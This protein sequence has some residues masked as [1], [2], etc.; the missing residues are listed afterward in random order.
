MKKPPTGDPAHDVLGYERQPLDAIFRPETVALIG[1]TDKAGSVGRTVMRNLIGNPF[2]GT[3]YPVNPKRPNV[4]GIKTYPSISEVP[5]QVDLAVIVSPAP[6]VPGIIRECAEA[7]V[8][9]AIVISA[10][11]KETGEEGVE[12][13][14]QVLE[15]A[16][17]GRIR[18]IGPNCLGVMSPVSGLNATFAGSMAL[19]GNVAFLSQSGA[20][21]TAILDWSQKENVGFSHFVSV[22]SMLDVDWGDLINYLGNDRHTKSIIV[23]MESI[24]DA[25][26]FLSAAREVALTKPVIVIKAGRTEAAGKAAAS[27]TG[28]LAGSDEVLD[29]A[30]RRSGV[31]R[32]DSISDLFYMAEV[33]AKQP[34][35]KGPKLTVVTNAGGPGVLATDALVT[36]GGELAKLSDETMQDLNGF[37]PAPWSHGN[38]V[39]V[40]GDAG[41]ERYEQAVEIAAKDPGSD[42]LLVVLTPQDMTDPTA[43]AEQLIRHAKTRGKPVLASWMGGPAVAQGEEILNKAGI[44]TFGYP[45][46]A[47][48][49]F[50]HMWRYTY[51][52]RGLYETPEFV[53]EDETD[54]ERAEEVIAE[55]R[56]EGRT[57]LTE[58]EAKE[59]LAAYGIPTVETAV[60]RDAEEAVRHAGEI[61][62]PVVLKLYSETITH[63]TDV[64]GVRLDLTDADAVR[65]AY[66]GIEASITEKAGAGHFDGVTVQPMISSEGYELIVGSSIDPQFGPVLLFGSG[67]QLVE[68]YK[69]SALA[70]PPLT[71]TLARRMM[72]RTRIV[73]ALKGVRGR[74]PVD[75]GAIERLLVR[76]SRLVVEQPWVR[77]LDVN[78]LLASPERLIALDARV[79]LHDLDTE[80]EELPRTAIRPY[81]GQYVSSSEM[82]DG[83]PITV[84]PIRPE[85]E[86]LMARFH[87][88]LSERS[89]YMRYF[90]AMNLTRRT[91]HERLTRICF[92]D[93]DREMALVAERENPDTGE[94]EI[95]GVARLSKNHVAQN[96]AE[97]SVLINDSFQRQGLGTVLLEKILEVGRDEGLG[98]VTAEILFENRAMQRLSKK[99]GFHLHRDPEEGVV[100]ADL[101]LYQMA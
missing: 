49:I 50:D 46:A 61:G 19:P 64:G 30:F 32:V 98:H 59:L 4:L 82:K 79:V 63:K 37:L 17:R 52:L 67:G 68:V 60:A 71:T 95:L 18:V 5:E 62:Y 70:L 66:E 93:Y 27:H 35:P 45:D 43:T 8:E 38:P 72:E 73:E 44:P 48:R 41:P 99:F 86:P 26:S 9:G 11:F 16:R 3:V 69:D 29:A 36:D 91:A 40:L 14:R 21:C 74:D 58:F 39:D 88:S 10:G 20:L 7:G 55:A 1:A 75:L 94:P 90:H 33:L 42:G 97:F 77:E 80:E 101:D 2:G 24:G 28:S 51:N 6:T 83:T 84:R 96:E 81:P 87:E 65:E 34:R 89:V 31:V 56:D 85:D 23:Y 12:L 25:R 15:E 13:E 76:F 92:I 47:A 100:K 22:G 78:P 57:L 53:E 54:R